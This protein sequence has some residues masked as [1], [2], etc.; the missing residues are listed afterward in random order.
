MVGDYSDLSQKIPAFHQNGNFTIHGLPK[1]IKGWGG[2]FA[3][4]N[5]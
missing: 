5:R 2:C 4:Q 1:L 3:N